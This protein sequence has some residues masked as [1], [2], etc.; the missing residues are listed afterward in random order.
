MRLHFEDLVIFCVLGGRDAVFLF[1]LP[2]EMIDAG[3]TAVF[4]NS[5]NGHRRIGQ[6]TLGL[7]NAQVQNVLLGSSI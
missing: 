6:Q 5:R 7:L 2:G 4:G 1:K 3:K